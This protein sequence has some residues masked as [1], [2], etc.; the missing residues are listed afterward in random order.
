MATVQGT[1][2]DRRTSSQGGQEA[3]AGCKPGQVRGPR[4]LRL[5]A[6]GATVHPP[7]RCSHF[8]GPAGELRKSAAADQEVVGAK[9]KGEP[10]GSPFSWRIQ[11]QSA[12]NA[13]LKV[14]LG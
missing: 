10:E 11:P 13:A 5:F 2:R 3:A 12:A 1:E 9:Q 7:G 4:P 14:A 8:A 6:A